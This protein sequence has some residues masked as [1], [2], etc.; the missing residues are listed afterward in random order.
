VNITEGD[1]NQMADAVYN[2]GAVSIAYEVVSDFKNYKSGV[3]TSTVCGNTPM[4]VNHAVTNIGY[5]NDPVSGLDYWLVKN[6]W[7]SS[8]GNNGY[9]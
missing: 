5:G 8:W 4:D 6:S 3:Y 2:H 7:G 9:F 1:E